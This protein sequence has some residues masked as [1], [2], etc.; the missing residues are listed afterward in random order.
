MPYDFLKSLDFQGG[1]DASAPALSPQSQATMSEG[2]WNTIISGS[3]LIRPFKGA[4]SQGSDT[5]ARKLLP[6]G[7]TW[8]GIRNISYS[9]KTVTAVDDVNDLFTTALHGFPTGLACTISTTVSVPAGLFTSTTYYIIRW[10]ATQFKLASSLAN[11]LAGNPI[12]ITNPGSGTHTINVTPTSVTAS[13]SFFQDIGRSRWG[14]G[15]GIPMIEGVPVPGFTLSTNLQVQI[16]SSGSYGTPVTAGLAQPS[17]PEVGI[18]TSV[19][20]VSNSVSVKISRTRPSTGAESLAS[21]VSAVIVPQANKIRVTFPAASTGQT[22]WRVYLSFQGFGGTGIHYLGTYTALQDIPESTVSAGTVDGVARSLE[23]NYKDGDLLPI[24]SSFDN[25]TPPAATHALRIQNVMALI[26][27]YADSVTGPTSTSPGTAIAVSKENNYEA[28][29]PTSLLFLPEPVVDVQARPKDDYGWIACQNSIHAIQ[30]VGDRGDGLP[31]CTLTTIL[32]DTG[33]QYHYNWCQFRGNML[34]Y[35]GDGN[36]MMMDSD[37]YVDTEFAAPVAKIL[38]SFTP[39]NTVVGYDPRN[40]SILVIRSTGHVLA[41]SLQAKKWRQVWLPDYGLDGTPR[42]CVTAKRDLYFTVSDRFTGEDVAYTYDTGSATSFICL[43]PN[44]QSAPPGQ[45]V[46]LY[47]IAMAVQTGLSASEVAVVINRSLSKTVYRRIGVTSG[48][49]TIVDSEASLG[50]EL[51]GKKVYIFGTGI[52]SANR[53]LPSTITNVG[54]APS[55]VELD[56]AGLLPTA[57]LEDCIMIVG[58]YRFLTSVN[59]TDPH[60]A[61]INPNVP[62]LRSYQLAVWFRSTGDIGNVLQCDLLG[63]NYLSSRA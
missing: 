63:T 1:V 52:N 13:G 44:Y 12:D 27:C 57:T 25:Y 62:E 38:K 48:D 37:G 45:V 49:G 11:A 31:S 34:I 22:H 30:Y 17:A 35:A 8:G 40:D 2:T 5:G 33:I 32:P 54:G 39:A 15:A 41:Y 59:K 6:F 18:T 51:L 50:V 20:D 19:G 60:L 56:P 61:N 14:I 46:D 36:L 21:P 42:A 55:T 26:G 58:D 53:Y 23:F 16:A 7:N 24:E 3:G 10:S 9:N 29:V 47:E 4:T 43:A 28:Y